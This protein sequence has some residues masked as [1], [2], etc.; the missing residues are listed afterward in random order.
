MTGALRTL[1]V[2]LR[3]APLAA[4]FLRVAPSADAASFP[5]D[6]RFSSVSTPRVTVHFHQGLEPMAR[7]TAALATRVLEAHEARYRHRIGRLQIVLA[8]NEDD[9]NGFASPLPYPLVS[10]RA[11]SPDGSDDFGNLEGWLELVITHELAHAVHLDEARGIIRLGRRVFGRAPFLFPNALTPTWMI[12]GLATYEETEGT[13]FG[14]GRN[15]DS[16]MVLRMAA[17][18]DRFPHQDQA[19]MGLDTWPSG[20]VSYLFGEAFLRDL[21]VRHGPHTVPELAHVQSGRVIPFTDDFTAHRVTGVAFYRQWRDWSRSAS[22]FYAAEAAGRRL[23]GLSASR[24]LTDRGIR[25]SAPRFRPDGSWIAYTSRTLTRYPTLRLVRPDGTDDRKL[26]DRSGGSGLAWTPDGQR[27]VYD[28]FRIDRLFS[29]RSDLRILELEGGRARW[30]TKGARARDPDVSPDGRSVAFVRRLGDRSE[31]AV[32]GL[33]GTEL[34]TLTESEPGTEWSGPRYRPQGD[35]LVASRLLP[36]G[37]LDLVEVDPATGSVTSLTEDRAKDVEPTWTPDGEYVVFRSDRD[38]VSN[39]YARRRSDGTLLRVSNVLGGAFAP[40]V[41]PDGRT[42]A[43]AS[44]SARGYDIHAMEADFAALGPAEPFIDPYPAPRP[45]P[46]P[47]SSR[48]RPYRPW[49][50]MRPRFWS[51]VLLNQDGELRYGVATAG[52]DP[53]FRHAYGIT[54][55]VGAE[56]SKL[57]VLGFY[58]YDRFRPTFLLT[59]E[60]KAELSNGLPYRTRT[61]NLRGT[62]PLRRTLRS[63]QSLSLTW[64]R[65][66]QTFD[67]LRPALVPVDRGGLETAWSL[68]TVQQYAESISPVDGARLRLAWLREAPAFGSD[69]ALSK[70]TGDARGY[71]RLLGERDVLAVRAGG[72][73]TLGQPGFTRSFSVGGFPDSNL[74]DLVRANVA[75]LRG[76]PDDAFI[77]RSFAHANLEYRVPLGSPQRGFRTLPFFLRHLRGT[78]FFDAAHAWTGEARLR[79][80]KTAGGVGLGVDSTLAHRLPFTG[81]VAL[82]RGFASRGFTKLYFR[83]GLAF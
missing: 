20:Q 42:V 5:P 23:A 78:L 81:E 79:D 21:T 57:S 4:A 17:L 3:A 58:Q 2:A 31:L 59:G 35:V 13:A 18:E 24:P 6:Y 29:R 64:R 43:F 39:L 10:V 44:Y 26:V 37:W 61:L 53:L 55:Y 72:G 7:E 51:P 12:E 75:L 80:V 9:P 8:D 69:V 68:S 65:E 36:G 49:P 54:S 83:L 66:R 77:G 15:P 27:L 25:Q 50:A 32:V 19:V 22:A 48:A 82:A 56:S 63:V 73:L 33:D 47:E 74:F 46:E 40:A 60:D 14:R 71:F 34:R 45:R 16:R 38:G 41:G 30:L 1:H 76:Y 52:A 67:D 70:L 28:D 62:L 11:A